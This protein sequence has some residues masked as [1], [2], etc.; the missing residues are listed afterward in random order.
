MNSGRITTIKYIKGITGINKNIG[1]YNIDPQ[2]PTS[3]KI[4][5]FANTAGYDRRSQTLNKKGE[6][7]DTIFNLETGLSLN[8][9]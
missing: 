6:K 4:N 3:L 8:C 1:K 2:Y 7:M 5:C 9:N